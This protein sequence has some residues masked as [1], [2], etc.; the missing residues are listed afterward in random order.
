MLGVELVPELGWLITVVPVAGHAARAEDALL[1]A[2]AFLVAADAGDD[3]VVPAL[4]D[5][6]LQGLRLARSRARRRRQRGIDRLDRRALCNDHVEAPDLG[7]SVPECVH[8]RHLLAG[9]DVDH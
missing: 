5:D 7:V 4:R 6:L 3:A 8:F 2:R 9:I 1:R